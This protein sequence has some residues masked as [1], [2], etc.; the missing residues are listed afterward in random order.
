MSIA[1]V[2]LKSRFLWVKPFLSL[3]FNKK[4]RHVSLFFMSYVCNGKEQSIITITYMLKTSSGCHRDGLQEGVS[5]QILV[6]R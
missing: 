1:Y 4:E 2:I 6:A 3:I 5:Q